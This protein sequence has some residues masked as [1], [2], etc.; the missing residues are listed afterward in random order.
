MFGQHPDVFRI[1]HHLQGVRRGP[2]VLQAPNLDRLV[3]P[4]IVI[5]VA[6]EEDPFVFADGVADQVVQA[7]VEI[8]L[9]VF[10]AIGKLAQGFRHRAVD[11][12][13]RSGDRVVGAYHAELELVAGKGEGRGAVAVGGVAVEAR[14][15]IRAEAQTLFLGPLVRAVRLDGIQHRGQLVPEEHRHDGRRRLVGT[16]AVVV[17]GRGR[18]HPQQPLIFVHGLDDRHQKD[19]KLRILIG[20]FPGTQ[21]VYAL[22]R[23]DGPVVVLAAAVDAGKGLFMQQADQTVLPGDLLH[24]LHGQLVVVRGDVRRGKNRRKLVLAGSDLVVLGLGID[25]ELPEL[26][27]QLFH[28]GLDAGLDRAEIMVV[29]LLAL[30]RGSTEERAAGINQVPALQIHVAVNEE[31]LLLGSGVR[32]HPLDIRVAEQRQDPHG[33]AVQRLHAAQQRRFLVQR[34][35]PVGAESR[36]DAEGLFL[37]E[38]IGGRVPG[39]VSS[40]FKGGTQTAGGEAGGIGLAGDEVSARELHNDMAVRCRGDKA[41]VLFG[42]DAGQR[43]EPVGKVCGAVLHRPVAHGGRHRVGNGQ[44]QLLA[45]VDGVAQAVIDIRGKPRPHDLVVKHQASE[46]FRYRTHLSPSRVS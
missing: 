11:H 29:Q 5:A 31:I 4:G 18:A 27:V 22:V 20:G 19:Q 16:E 39:G 21:Q 24:D 40:G 13:V 46:Q 42:R 17:S 37:D 6:V 33:L 8:A 9:T 34:L 12:G 10:Q 41:V 2:Q 23:R 38:G 7:A 14:Q 36:R 15:H 45:L 3:N 28:E 32:H 44:V 26:L 30:G 35:A 25:A 1:E 43:L